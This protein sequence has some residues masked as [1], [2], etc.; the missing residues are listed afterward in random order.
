MSNICGNEER[1]N[2][3]GEVT[4]SVGGGGDHKAQANSNRRREKEGME[5]W[6]EERSWGTWTDVIDREWGSSE[7]VCLVGVQYQ[8]YVYLTKQTSESGMRLGCEPWCDEADVDYLPFYYFIFLFI[9]IYIKD[10]MKIRLN[11]RSWEL[12]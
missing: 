3:E 4:W 11:M 6:Q 8:Q 9:I 5:A 2:G 10:H 1:G 12:I 7:S